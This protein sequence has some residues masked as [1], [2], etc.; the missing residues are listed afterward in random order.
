MNHATAKSA[1][2]LIQSGKVKVLDVRTAAE[3]ATGYIAGAVNIDFRSATF[4]QQLAKLDRA[5]HWLVHCASGK[6]STAALTTLA[7]LGF[8][9]VTHLDGGFNAWQQAGLPVAR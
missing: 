9:Q 6:R 7:E 8:K 4:A 5:Q 2:T 1:A 3:F